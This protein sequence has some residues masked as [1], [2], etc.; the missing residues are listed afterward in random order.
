MLKLLLD[1]YLPCVISA[2]F[3]IL[4][5]AEQQQSGQQASSQG[6]PLARGEGSGQA[7]SVSGMILWLVGKG[8]RVSVALREALLL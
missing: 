1:A 2:C 7:G 4:V 3:R 8:G 5:P 6:D